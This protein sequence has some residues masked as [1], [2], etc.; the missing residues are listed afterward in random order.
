MEIE[1]VMFLSISSLA[2][3][4]SNPT[5]TW[6]DQDWLAEIDRVGK[7]EHQ[8]SPPPMADSVHTLQFDSTGE[9]FE[10]VEYELQ[11]PLALRDIL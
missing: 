11:R 10:T 2:V 9:Y 4:K 3:S 1:L 7:F 5:W 8:V 6:P